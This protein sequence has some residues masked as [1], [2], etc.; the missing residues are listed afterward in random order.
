[1]FASWNLNFQVNLKKIFSREPP[2]KLEGLVNDVV[3]YENM[4]FLYAKIIHRRRRRR[5]RKIVRKSAKFF[6]IIFLYLK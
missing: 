3:F 6:N 4:N 2:A 5:R 1:M